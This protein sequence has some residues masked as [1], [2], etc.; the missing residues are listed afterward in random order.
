MKKLVAVLLLCLSA[1]A[2]AVTVGGVALEEKARIGKSNLVLNGAGIRT[3]IIFKVYVAA[4]YLGEKKG[5]A[6]AVLADTGAKRVSLHM[7]R[8]VSAG[9]FMD[10]FNKAINANH[11]PEQYAALAARLMDFGRV[12]REVG[13]V[14]KG[15]VILIDY[16]P[17]SAETLLTVNGKERVRIKGADFYAAMLKI[18]LGKNPVQDS[19]K[20]A[21][22]GG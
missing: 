9:D 11:T 3:K 12:F 7:L 10:A 15:A 2:L 8:H 17:E 5:A 21:M 14:D 1:Q 13:E 22:L 6:D 19:L 20:K 4:L 16:L 18:W